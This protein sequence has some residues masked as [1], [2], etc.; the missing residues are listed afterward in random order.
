MKNWSLNDGR[1]IHYRQAGS[2]PPLVLLHGWGMSSAVFGEALEALQD[3]FL[4]LAPDLPGHGPSTA[5]GDY[6]LEALAADLAAWMEGLQLQDVRLLGWSLGGQIALRLADGA[7]QRLSRL[8]L[9]ATTPRFVSD[10]QW[11]HGLAAGRVRVM[12]RGLR[13][14]PAGVLKEFF[15]SMFTANELDGQRRQWLTEQCSPAAHP[16]QPTAVLGA[17]QTL[18]DSD[19]RSWVKD[20]SLP[21][22]LQHGSDDAIVPLGAG[23][24]LAEILPKARLQIL[25]HQ[26]HAPFLSGP[27][28]SFQGWREFCRS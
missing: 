19:L 21:V 5:T 23:R 18:R 15:A 16:P 17:L 4:V 9:V 1:K 2:G 27:E 10:P 8:I 13:R 28:Q 25:N 14:D 26:G 22:L 6:G 24:Y 7:A 11:P 12:E 3:Q 20:L